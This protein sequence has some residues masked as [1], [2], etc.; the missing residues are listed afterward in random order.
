MGV[1]DL[2]ESSRKLILAT[3]WMPFL[4]EEGALI[5][6]DHFPR[7]LTPALIHLDGE[8]LDDLFVYKQSSRNEI[9]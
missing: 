8:L 7:K 4:P 2:P 5:Q 1:A 9:K 6:R 3:L